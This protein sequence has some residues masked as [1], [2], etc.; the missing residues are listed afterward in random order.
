M[1][2]PKS[3]FSASSPPTVNWLM[4]SKISF[5][6]SNSLVLIGTMELMTQLAKVVGS[7]V[8]Q[9]TRRMRENNECSSKVTPLVY[10]LWHEHWHLELLVERGNRGLHAGSKAPQDGPHL[11]SALMHCKLSCS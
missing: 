1:L 5:R 2:V 4:G 3:I 10:H 11:C 8:S 9:N 7:T 6:P